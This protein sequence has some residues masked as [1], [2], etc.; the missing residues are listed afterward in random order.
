MCEL[1]TDYV[2]LFQFHHFDASRPIHALAT[3]DPVTVPVN[4][5]LRLDDESAA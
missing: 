1:D 5:E 4:K 2:D 3:T